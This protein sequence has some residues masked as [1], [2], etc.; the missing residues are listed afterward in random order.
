ME[1]QSIIKVLLLEDERADA[2][3]IRAYLQSR[4]QTVKSSPAYDVHLAQKTTTAVDMLQHHSF[5]II[6]CD[7]TLPDSHGLDTFNR[8]YEI[9]GDTPIVILSGYA[10]EQIAL[11]AVKNGAQDYIH[12]ND[13]SPSL[14]SRVAVSMR[15]NIVCQRCM[16]SM[17]R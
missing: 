6:L 16:F 8:L 1:T 4:A 14:L 9:A 3:L 17:L 11:E 13:L 5:D 7:L 12:K 15:S 10:D 2:R